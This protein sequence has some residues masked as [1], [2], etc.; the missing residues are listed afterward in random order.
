VKNILISSSYYAFFGILLKLLSFLVVMW[1]GRTLSVEEYAKFGLLYSLQQGV[2]TFSVAGIV[3]SIIGFLKNTKYNRQVLFNNAFF[4]ALPTCSVVI[5]I[6]S[7]YFLVASNNTQL[8]T[9]SFMSALF[10]GLFLA[11]FD[12]KAKLYRLDENHFSAIL[13]LVL[14]LATTFI[15]GF[16][17]VFW[18]GGGAYFYGSLLGVLLSFICLAKFTVMATR[19][20]ID[21]E[22]TK[23]IA[24][25][26]KPFVAV[27]LIGWFS[28]YGNNFIINI[29][30][31]VSEVAKYTFIYTLTG[32]MLVFAGM[33]NNV[34]SPHF[35]NKLNTC[36]HE[37][38]EKKNLQFYSNLS[39]VLGL[40]GACVILV[41]KHVLSYVGGGL[42]AYLG[43]ELEL[44]FLLLAYVV[45]VPSWHCRN[46]FYV[47][48]KGKDLMKI[49]LLSGAIGV[50]LSI[51]SM[52]LL[53]SI[54]IYVG[55]LVIMAIQTFYMVYVSIREWDIQVSWL[56]VCLGGVL[57]C[58][59]Y[60]AVSLGI[61]FP[62]GLGLVMISYM[63]FFACN[64]FLVSRA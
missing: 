38:I 3:E 19:W 48:T 23:V 40:V 64:Y 33:L 14:P 13:M 43:M 25:N 51:V 55:F 57:I 11:Y 22:I 42:T 28:G 63:A 6:A 5:I 17:A 60:Y 37:E 39:L 15:I 29:F 8:T 49:S 7:L 36:T 10:A 45:Y 4:A 41:Y 44:C 58:F 35:Y 53:G 59:A 30:F 54:G 31:D 46:Y 18:Y 12:L 1:L 62:I 26:A 20:D 2:L 9:T 16:L 50:S 47:K 32:V 34:W 61:S 56:A 52:F 24:N 21:Q 27:T